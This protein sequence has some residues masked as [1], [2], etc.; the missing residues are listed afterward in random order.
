MLPSAIRRLSNTPAVHRLAKRLHLT[1]LVR[2][3][4]CRLLTTNGV[5]PISCLGIEAGLKAHNSKQM[6][7]MDYIWTTERE[8][9]EAALCDLRSGDTFLDVGCHYGIF[10]I[11]ASKI[12][13]PA[14]RVIAVEPHPGALEVLQ[15]N[16]SAN[17]CENIEILNLA[18]SDVTSPLSLA[19][20]ENGAGIQRESDPASALHMVQGMAGDEALRKTPIPAVVKIDVEGHEFEVLNGLKQTLSSPSCRRL[21]LEIHPTLLP[22]GIG[23]DGIVEFI[24]GCGLDVLSESARPPAL[25]VVAAR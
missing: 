13:G 25:H 9:I 5:L 1:Q 12:V 11:L 10:S 20:N 14:G 2:S 8:F 23:R 21:C 3:L 24:R 18:L 22:S 17:F 19:F 6:V 15:R 16:I 7:F 4:Y